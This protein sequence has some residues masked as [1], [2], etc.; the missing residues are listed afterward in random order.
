MVDRILQ[1]MRADCIPVGSSGLWDVKRGVI[2]GDSYQ[3]MLFE[4]K[5]FF[6]SEYRCQFPP[7]GTYTYLLRW[8]NATLHL[9]HGE[10]VMNDFP[11][12]LKKHLAFIMKARGDVLVTGLGLG[13]VVRGLLERGVVDSIDVIERDQDVI[14]LCSIGVSHPK[15]RIIKADAREFVPER[16]YHAAWHDLWSDPDKG[17]DALSLT[18]F[19]LMMKL[20]DVIPQ[21]GAWALPRRITRR[22]PEFHY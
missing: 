21:Q 12:E 20:M 9:S 4:T 17:E 22:L 6:D 10:L 16:T 13:C 1:A 8:T 14:D 2:V 5:N 18:H 3:K 11:G 7:N 19:K 15:V